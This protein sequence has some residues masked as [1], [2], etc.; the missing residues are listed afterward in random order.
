MSLT[1]RSGGNGGHGNNSDFNSCNFPTVLTEF[2]Y[3]FWSHCVLI[4]LGC[5]LSPKIFCYKQ[6]FWAFIAFIVNDGRDYMAL[7]PLHWQ[8]ILFEKSCH[9]AIFLRQCVF[10]TVFSHLNICQEIWIFHCFENTKSNVTKITVTAW[11]KTKKINFEETLI[12]SI[13]N[14][15]VYDQKCK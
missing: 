5:M 10:W 9:I 11:Q 3:D 4:S 8:I 15:Q 6:C 13:S 1:V 14:I 2:R 12:R 7:Q